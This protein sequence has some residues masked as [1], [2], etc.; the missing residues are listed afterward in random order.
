MQSRKNTCGS[1]EFVF[2]AV[3]V[4]GV[5]NARPCR[6][7]KTCTRKKKPMNAVRSSV[8]RCVFCHPQKHVCG[9]GLRQRERRHHCKL[10]DYKRS[11]ASVGRQRSGGWGHAVVLG[12][13]RA[14]QSEAG[15]ASAPVKSVEGASED[16]KV[17]WSRLVKVGA[18]CGKQNF[19]CSVTSV[20][21]CLIVHSCSTAVC[22]NARTYRCWE[23]WIV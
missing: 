19:C 7:A 10:P 20:S 13:C 5:E 9:Y 8:P 6:Q 14:S 17:I 2:L 18:L 4:F 15:E 1:T 3:Q 11:F 12:T 16:F 23:C 21:F 22:P